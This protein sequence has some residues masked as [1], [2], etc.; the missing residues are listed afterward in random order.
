MLRDLNTTRSPNNR[1]T[2]AEHLRLCYHGPI[3]E[4]GL[5]SLNP[6]KCGTAT[7]EIGRRAEMRRSVLA[8]L[9]VIA[10][11]IR[12]ARCRLLEVQ[13]FRCLH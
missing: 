8:A 5:S 9:G 12:G 1:F 13:D 6:R 7:A 4:Y 3:T 2:F 11:E 10:G